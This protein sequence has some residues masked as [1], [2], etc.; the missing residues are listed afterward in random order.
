MCKHKCKKFKGFAKYE[1]LNFKVSHWN[2]WSPLQQ[3]WATVQPV[4]N[5]A[6]AV[7]TNHVGLSMFLLL[8]HFHMCRDAG[9]KIWVKFF[10]KTRSP[11]HKH[12]CKTCRNT[13]HKIIITHHLRCHKI[14]LWHVVSEFTE[15]IFNDH[16]FFSQRRL[17]VMVTIVVC[18]PLTTQ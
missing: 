2:G 18:K 17:V 12:C 15:F 7:Y 10:L 9:I 3:C 16:N 1:G 5:I 6:H 11:I 14:I 4:I 13:C 8:K